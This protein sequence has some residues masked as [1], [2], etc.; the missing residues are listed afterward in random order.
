MPAELV[1]QVT[2]V[3]M[4][5]VTLLAGSLLAVVPWLT[6]RREAFAVTVPESAQADPRIARMRRIRLRVSKV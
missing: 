3:T 4:A 1:S 5:L 2:G 6:R